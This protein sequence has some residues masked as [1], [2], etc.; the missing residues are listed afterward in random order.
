MRMRRFLFCLVAIA[1]LWGART[2]AQQAFTLEQV[3]SAPFPASLVT[4][5]TGN[6]LAWTLDQQGRRNIWVAQ[7]PDFTARQLTSYK[8]DDGGVRSAFHCGQ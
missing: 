1:L 5:K 4:A 3:L 8:E 2:A 7:G 6:R